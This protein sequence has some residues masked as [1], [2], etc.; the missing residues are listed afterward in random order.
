MSL[1]DS[2]GPAN[3]DDVVTRSVAAEPFLSLRQSFS[4]V[5]EALSTICRVAAEGARRI[6]AGLRDK[7]VVVSRPVDDGDNLD[8]EIGYT[9]FR[10]T[11]AAIPI[12]ENLVLTIGEL[13]AVDTMATIVRHGTNPESH[14]AFGTVGAWIEANGCEI[15]GPCREVFLEPLT[16]LSSLEDVLVEIQFPVR[17]AA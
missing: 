7:L 10:P 14:R 16:D 13:S 6:R 2:L 3:T 4:V 1:I 8:L 17:I 11:N 5:D 9:L 12:A 15:A